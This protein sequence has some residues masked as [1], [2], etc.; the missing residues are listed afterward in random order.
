[1]LLDYCLFIVTTQCL[2]FW[3][4]DFIDFFSTSCRKILNLRPCPFCYKYT[5]ILYIIQYNTQMLRFKKMFWVYQ[6][7]AEKDE[8]NKVEIGKIRPTTTLMIWRGE[9]WRYRRVRLT[10]LPTETWEHDLLPRLSCGTSARHKERCI[11]NSCHPFQKVSDP[12][13]K[14]DILDFKFLIV[15]YSNLLICWETLF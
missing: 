6:K 14:L 10:L 2:L 13:I 9:R 8:G 12:Y 1:M 7:W 5:T 3:I 11:L 4:I 15:L